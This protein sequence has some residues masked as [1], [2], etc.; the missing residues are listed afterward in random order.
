MYAVTKHLSYVWFV[1]NSGGV[2]PIIKSRPC[3]TLKWLIRNCINWVT[4]L[5]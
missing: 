2:P 5:H 1:C 3:Q 4:L